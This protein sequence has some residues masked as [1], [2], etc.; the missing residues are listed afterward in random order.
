MSDII[1]EEGKGVKAPMKRHE[2]LIRALLYFALAVGVCSILPAAK[3]FAGMAAVI[4]EAGFCVLIML[5]L[6]TLENVKLYKYSGMAK[7]KKLAAIDMLCICAGMIYW[8]VAHAVWYKKGEVLFYDA[9][10]L[11]VLALPYVYRVYR[12]FGLPKPGAA[13]SK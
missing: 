1:V 13:K 10:I 2:V 5:V 6:F 8:F 3:E 11:A 12:I 7:W 9:I 4:F